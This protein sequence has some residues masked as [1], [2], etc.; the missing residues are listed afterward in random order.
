MGLNP[1]WKF[2]V[3]TKQVTAEECSIAAQSETLFCD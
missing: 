2:W 1:R 3:E